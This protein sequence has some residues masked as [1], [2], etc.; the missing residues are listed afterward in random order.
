MPFVADVAVHGRRVHG[1]DTSEQVTREGVTTGRGGG[2]YTVGS[3]HVV[4][5][6]EVDGVIGDTNACG[7][8]HGANP[9]DV[10]F[11]AEGGP[12]E[13]EETN[14]FEWREPE[15]P[16]QTAFGGDGIVALGLTDVLIAYEP[17]EVREIRDEVGDVNGDDSPGL[18]QDTPAPPLLV[19]DGEALEEGEDQ[20]VGETGQERHGQDN[21]L[22]DEH[23]ERT[24]PNLASFMKRDTRLF[25]LVGA[26]DVGVLA[27]L[28][29][30][31]G[32]LVHDDSGTAFGHEEHDELN[33]SSE[34]ELDPEEPVPIEEAPNWTTDNTTNTCTNAGR[35]DDKR[36]RKLLRVGFVQVGNQTKSDTT[37]SG[38]NTTLNGI[39]PLFVAQS[40]GR[41]EQNLPGHERRESSPSWEPKQREVARC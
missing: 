15:K 4:D 18:T 24:D 17:R 25:Q 37:T 5:G 33:N 29:T 12:G 11:P 20:S 13:A 23:V 34:H 19:D 16:F 31:L 14:G 3:H 28:A 10:A 32:F 36:E 7:E 21:G 2:V 26:I 1:R 38:R 41:H 6:G 8:D 39:S 40:Q 9:V 35:Q 30:S 27:S 22:A